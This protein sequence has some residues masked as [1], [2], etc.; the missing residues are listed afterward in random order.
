MTSAWLLRD[1]HDHGGHA[2]DHDDDHDHDHHEPAAGHHHDH[3]RDLNLRAAYVHVLADAAVS[4]LAVIGLV[5]G[6]QLGWIWMDP[7]MGIVGACVIANWSWGLVRAAGAV[8]LDLR[9]DGA[10]A[11]GVRE[12]LERDGDRVADLHLWRVGPGHAAAIVSI[13]SDRPE[14]PARYKARLADLRGLSHVTIE[15]LPC[16]GH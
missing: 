6:R 13:V 7:L 15:V 10:L 4:V 2:H 5:T 8:L 12:R 16:P 3:H 14:A 9:P 1:E 11:A